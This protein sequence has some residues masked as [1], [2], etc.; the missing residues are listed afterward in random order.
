MDASLSTD[1]T[2]IQSFPKPIT[3]YLEYELRSIFGL[4]WFDRLLDLIWAYLYDYI[5]V[6]QSEPGEPWGLHEF[7]L[8]ALSNILM[9]LII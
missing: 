1:K 3:N 9:C 6:F 7:C 5:R 2:T 4:H 8:G